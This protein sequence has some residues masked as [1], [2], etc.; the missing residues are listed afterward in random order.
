MEKSSLDPTP[1]L[2]PTKLTI[3]PLKG[4]IHKSTLNPHVRAAHNYNVVE[5]LAQSPSMIST[6]EVFQNF[7]TKNRA[8]LLPSGCV[9]PLDSNLV[10]L[11]HENYTPWLKAQLD[12]IIQVIIHGKNIH[13]SIMD[14]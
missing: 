2:I 12:F 6:L 11:S 3:K 5:D 9:D 7:A 8:L 14:V 13:P 10:V 1:L 4:V